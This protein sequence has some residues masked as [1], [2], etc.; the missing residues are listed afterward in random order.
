MRFVV[1]FV[2]P[3]IA[4]VPLTVTAAVSSSGPKPGTGNALQKNGPIEDP[5]LT[6]SPRIV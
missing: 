3:S 5:I 4:S 6:N 2:S 1:F